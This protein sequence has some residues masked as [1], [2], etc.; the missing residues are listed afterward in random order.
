MD[1]EEFSLF[2]IEQ[3]I[4]GIDDVRVTTEWSTD[5]DID[6]VAKWGTEVTAVITDWVNDFTVEISFWGTY[7]TVVIAVE[8][9]GWSAVGLVKLFFKVIVGGDRYWV[10]YDGNR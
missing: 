5:D 3:G 7:V 10:W 9:T 4:S 6:G 8:A 1:E 2:I